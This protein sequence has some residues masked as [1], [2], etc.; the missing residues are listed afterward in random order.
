MLPGICAH[1]ASN[2]GAS[3]PEVPQGL[4]QSWPSWALGRVVGKAGAMA[5]IEGV[6]DEMT[7]LFK[8]LACLLM[9]ALTRVSTHTSEGADPLPQASGTPT[10]AQP[11]EA[12]VVT[13]STIE[14]APGAKAPSPRNRGQAAQPGPGTGLTATPAPLDS[15]RLGI[16]STEA[17]IPQ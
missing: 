10:P 2:H 15:P 9:L 6:G 16:P 14:E 1:D 5:L 17:G 11:S 13:N 7:V 8:V 3:S 4:L 12:M